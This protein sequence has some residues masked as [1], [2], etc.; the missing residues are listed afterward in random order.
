[1]KSFFS[2]KVTK[3]RKSNGNGAN[4]DATCFEMADDTPPS[5]ASALITVNVTTEIHVQ[6]QMQYI[7]LY[8]C[9]VC[10]DDELSKRF[11]EIYIAE[12]KLQERM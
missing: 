10:C 4:C 6:H 5:S 2:C 3:T 9:H 12:R 1:M 11:R 8:G 7:V